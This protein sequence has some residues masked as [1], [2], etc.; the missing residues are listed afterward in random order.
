M[1]NKGPLSGITVIDLTAMI[2]GP[3]CTMML[4]DQG[5]DVIKVEPLTG[6]LTRKVG[7]QKNGMTTS[8]LCANRSKRSITLN[9]KD[10]KGI[11]I[12]KK[13]I[14][15]A[16]VLVQNF[17]PGTMKR[18]GLNYEEVKKI[19]KEI[20]YVSISGFGEKGPYANHRVYDPVIQALSG[21]ADIQRDQKTNFP[22]MVRTIIPDK[23]TGM[24]A[25]Q[26]ISSALFYKER[27]GKGQHIKL[28]MLDVMVAYLWPEGS[29]SLSFI[30]EEGD[31]SD[32]QMGLDLVF[33]TK[34]S[35]YI[36]AGAVTDKEWLG[37][38]EA[39]ERKDLLN[40]P[41]FNTPRARFENKTERRLLIAEEIKKHNAEEILFKLHK[42]EVP[43]A[44]ILT[45]TELLKNEQIV[46][47]EII[48]FHD[49]KIFGTIR[50]PRPAPIYSDSPI[51][52]K[53][54]APLMG[55]NSREILKE[56]NYKDEEIDNFIKEKVISSTN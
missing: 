27:Y 53:Q 39:L 45:R 55:E 8:F 20:I 28:A 47:N 54:L 25:A 51:N 12:L 38:C 46:A 10:K 44:P 33:E 50:S 34:D 7:K 5:A 15:N 19:N 26:A 49:S 6:E 35:K 43:S 56:I 40:D 36:T 29:A 48:E 32:G 17:R 4:G 3:V 52:G 18:M 13:L 21:L 16:D 31:P 14:K 9:L 2:S 30:G 24:A 41:R 11:N 42:N 23:T 37:M 1:K 22:K